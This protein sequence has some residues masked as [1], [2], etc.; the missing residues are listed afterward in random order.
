MSVK[1]YNCFSAKP[2]SCVYA[3][4][5]SAECGIYSSVDKGFYPFQFVRLLFKIFSEYEK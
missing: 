3:K 5:P 4:H 1:K 2:L